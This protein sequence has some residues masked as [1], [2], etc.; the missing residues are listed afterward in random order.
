MN[1]EPYVGS[2]FNEQNFKIFLLGESHHFGEDDMTSFL[3]EP[4]KYKHITINVLKVF[5][6]YKNG[7]TAFEHWMNTFSRFTNIFN[8]SNANKEQI[9]ELWNSLSF[10]NYV[11]TPVDSVRKSPTIEQFKDSHDSFVDILNV[12]K[13]NLIIVWGYRLWYNM[14]KNESLTRKNE[15]D[16]YY[17]IPI[18][19]IP[20]PSS[21]KFDYS[22]NQFIN[23]YIEK[24]KNTLP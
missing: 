18:L 14:P 7:Q 17:N 11:Q 4:L 3:K 21:S 16:Y 15:I 8:N 6:K 19:V 13:P 23:D 2:K 22:M 1:F 5:F 9:M 10:Y 24:I 12:L 20:H